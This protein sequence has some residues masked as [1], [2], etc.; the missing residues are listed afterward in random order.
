MATLLRRRPQILVLAGLDEL[1][2]VAAL[3]TAEA[4]RLAATHVA[5]VWWL[6]AVDGH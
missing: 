6:R 5:G 3:G 1:G 4:G 2:A